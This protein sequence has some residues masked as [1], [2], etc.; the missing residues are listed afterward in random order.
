MKPVE[1][2][3]GDQPIKQAK[4]DSVVTIVPDE[5]E[6]D[7]EADD[8]DT[9]IPNDDAIDVD[10]ESVEEPQ[11]SQ[12][13]QS[14]VTQPSADLPIYK[15]KLGKP[16]QIQRP[17]FTFELLDIP[18]GAKLYFTKDPSKCVTVHNKK[19]VLFEEMF[20]AEPVSLTNLTKKLLDL[21][22]DIQPTGYWTYEGTT[23]N[24]LYYDKFPDTDN[25]PPKSATL[26]QT[27][28]TPV[29]KTELQFHDIH[30]KHTANINNA[31]KIKQDQKNVYTFAFAEGS[32]RLRFYLIP[33]GLPLSI[34]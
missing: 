27:T 19:T 5:E 33:E 29:S 32:R 26:Q 31:K 21:P 7:N 24:K 4:S 23:L 2:P 28:R 3:T 18:V 14:P 13:S 25:K 11:T 1:K 8:T 15:S 20:G 16:Q 22:R 10:D 30:K 34:Q 17:L 12:E 9:E 6:D